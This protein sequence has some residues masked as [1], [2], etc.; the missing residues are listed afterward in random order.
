MY[1]LGGQKLQILIQ[2]ILLYKFWK[3]VRMRKKT[4]YSR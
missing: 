4:F 1:L 2:N 3:K